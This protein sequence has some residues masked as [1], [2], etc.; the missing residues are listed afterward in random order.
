MKNHV[1]HILATSNAYFVHYRRIIEIYDDVHIPLNT[2]KS[3]ISK[4]QL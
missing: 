4:S 1:A 2:K 3:G